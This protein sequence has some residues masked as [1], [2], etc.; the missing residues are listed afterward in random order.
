M[1]KSQW[2]RES[3]EKFKD[4]WTHYPSQDNEGYRPDRGGFKA[5]WYWCFEW[6]WPFYYSVWCKEVN[7]TLRTIELEECL[8]RIKR[9]T[10][11]SPLL[12][13]GAIQQVR[14]VMSNKP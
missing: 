2:L 12:T 11:L 4:A 13:D 7:Q 6:L 10:K 5:G 8:E 3:H 14:V 1:I 9:E